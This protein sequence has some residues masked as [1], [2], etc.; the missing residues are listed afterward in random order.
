MKRGKNTKSFELAFL[1][2]SL[3]GLAIAWVVGFL[4]KEAD[5][6]PHLKSVLSEATRFEPKGLDIYAGWKDST[7][8]N[9]CGYICAQPAQGYGGELLLL[10]GINSEGIIQSLWV[11]R[12]QETLPFYNRVLKKNFLQHLIQKSYKEKFLLHQDIDVVSGATYTCRA[13]AQAAGKGVKR[14]AAEILNLEVDPIPSPK[15][16][17][18][19]EEGILL[20]LFL[21]ATFGRRFSQK[22]NRILRWVSMGTSILL[23]GFILNKPLNLIFIN[24]IL[25]GEWPLWQTHLYWYL[26]IGGVLFFIIIL[27]K[28]LYCDR[29]CPMGALQETVGKVGGAKNRITPGWHLKL[30]WIQRI[31]ALIIIGAA[32]AFNHPGKFNYEI[33]GSMFHLIGNTALFALT[34]LILISS[35]FLIRPWCHYLCPVRGVADALKF[36][37]S[38][39]IRKKTPLEGR[40]QPGLVNKKQIGQNGTQ[41]ADDEKETGH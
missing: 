38:Q 18:G 12:H 4:Q 1:I 22:I 36:L 34:G 33:S 23:L 37:R 20:I 8:K 2:F 30:R 16:Q 26:M 10:V 41:Q 39:L 6:V 9:L 25:M 24:R 15:L 27:N 3:L 29:I 19:W 32:L 14:V 35:L 5:I 13:L 17:W 28:N 31:L 11:A 7:K 21:F 40:G